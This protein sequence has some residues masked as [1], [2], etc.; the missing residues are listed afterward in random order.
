M[1]QRRD[2]LEDERRMLT[3]CIRYIKDKEIR[4]IFTIA[5]F[6]VLDQLQELYQVKLPI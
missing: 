5:Y 3:D 4:P 2:K 1:K 6:Q